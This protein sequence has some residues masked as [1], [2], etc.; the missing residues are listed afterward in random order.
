MA[1]EIT[2]WQHV[3]FQDGSN[4]YICKTPAEFARIKRKYKQNLVNIRDNFWMVK[5]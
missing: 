2:G 4:P 1:K 3:S 5:M